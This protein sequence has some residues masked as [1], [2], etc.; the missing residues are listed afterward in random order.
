M[1]HKNPGIKN[2]GSVVLEGK[3]S[4]IKWVKGLKGDLR[5]KPQATNIIRAKC[6]N[7]KKREFRQSTNYTVPKIRNIYWQKEK[8]AASFPISTFMYL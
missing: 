1:I 7:N 6:S 4:G 2:A 3:E 5:L 8:C